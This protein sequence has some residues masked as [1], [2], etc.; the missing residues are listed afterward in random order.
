VPL[1]QKVVKYMLSNIYIKLENCILEDIYLYHRDDVLHS[2][3][4]MSQRYV[5]L[6]VPAMA[7]PTRRGTRGRKPQLGIGSMV[8][9]L[10]A[11]NKLAIK[12]SVIN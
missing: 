10:V 3:L 9:H 7:G 4:V 6:V 5:G 2:L 12:V 8:H 1:L 11:Q